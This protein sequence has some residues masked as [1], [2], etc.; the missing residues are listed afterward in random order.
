MPPC[1]EGGKGVHLIGLSATIKTVEE[2]ARCDF[3]NLEAV[4]TEK[5]RLFSVR[6]ICASLR[7][8]RRER[9]SLNRC[10]GAAESSSR[11]RIGR[12][13]LISSLTSSWRPETSS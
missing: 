12:L 2:I 9:A 3:C 10:F 5:I 11:K 8:E 6:T 7:A 4:L 1:P 13:S